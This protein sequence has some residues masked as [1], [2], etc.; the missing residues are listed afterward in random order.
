MRGAPRFQPWL[1]TCEALAQEWVG[2]LP[3]AFRH[4][5][6]WV[7]AAKIP[8]NRNRISNFF[9]FYF[10]LMFFGDLALSR[11][12]RAWPAVGVFTAPSRRICRALR[13]F[14]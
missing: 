9:G 6:A 8:P 14:P 3:R 11:L 7:E 13:S 1:I 5:A 2:I 12:T 10:A 4:G